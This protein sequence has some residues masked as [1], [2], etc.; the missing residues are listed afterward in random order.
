MTKGTASFIEK[1][2]ETNSKWKKKKDATN[3]EDGIV[4]R[5]AKNVNGLIDKD[6]VKAAKTL[7]SKKK[8][9]GSA[10]SSSSYY[11]P[12]S[13]ITDSSSDSD[14]SSSDDKK[15]RS[16]KKKSRKDDN[17]DKT[18]AKAKSKVRKENMIQKLTQSMEEA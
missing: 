2:A 15:E 3:T 11:D 12:S 16:K 18:S 4:R 13:S 14:D 9:K 17:N 7:S 6:K 5:L 10:S 1:L 8:K